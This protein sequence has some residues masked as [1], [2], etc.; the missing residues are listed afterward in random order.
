MQSDAET[1]PTDVAE[2]GTNKVH[3]LPDLPTK[4][5]AFG[6]HRDL[7]KAIA[8]LV[9]SED[10]GKAIALEGGW[11]SGKSSVVLMLKTQLEGDHPES[12]STRVHVFD[13]WSHEGDPLRRVF[14]E[15]LTR[16]CTSDLDTKAKK[17]WE[18]RQKKEITGRKRET[19]QTTTPILK[20]RWPILF[21]A[22]L[23][24]YPVAIVALS[25]LFREDMNSWFFLL[26][27]VAAVIA[28]LPM[29]LLVGLFF[30]SRSETE[31]KLKKAGR[32]IALWSKKIDETTTTTAH[33]NFG[34]TSIEFQAYFSDLLSEY[35]ED[36]K[37][38]LILVLDN[39][40]RVPVSTARKLWVTL[41]VFADCCE[42]SNADWSKRVWFVVP[43]DPSAV[44]RIW[45]D[46][47]ELKNDPPDQRAGKRELIEQDAG[48]QKQVAQPV[49]PRL[50]AAFLDKTFQIRFDVPPLLLADWK[51]YLEALLV[52]AFGEGEV[53]S[54]EGHRVYWLS[55]TMTQEKKRP[56]TPR[57]LILYV[58]DIG[59]LKRRFGGI[60]PL[61]H[62]ALYAI[63]RRNGHDVRLWLLEE[64]EDR[65]RFA[66]LLGG[67]A[68]VDSLCAI[69][70][71]TTNVDAARS[72]LFREPILYYLANGESE[73][74]EKLVPVR[75]F[76][77]E[78]D[79]ICREG[80]ASFGSDEERVLNTLMVIELCKLIEAD[81]K[82][83]SSLKSFLA[84]LVTTVEWT[85]LNGDTGAGAATAIHFKL[86][87]RAS[88]SILR[89][90]ASAPTTEDVDKLTVADW[91]A[92]VQ[93]IATALARTK[94][95][96]RF[97]GVIQIA[98]TQKTI[99]ILAEIFQLEDKRR[100]EL[101]PLISLTEPIK[102]LVVSLAPTA[103]AEW[104]DNY[105]SATRALNLLENNTVPWSI[106]LDGIALRMRFDASLAPDE[107]TRLIDVLYELTETNEQA[108]LESVDALVKDG[109]L[110]RRIE[111]CKT[112]LNSTT[113]GILFQWA[114]EYWELG[115]VLPAITGAA[116]GLDVV[117]AIGQKPE[118]YPI[119]LDSIVTNCRPSDE[120][121]LL[122]CVLA[123]VEHIG[124]LAQIVLDRLRT[125]GQLGT[126]LDANVFV[127]RYVELTA[128]HAS[129]T[130]SHDSIDA[131]TTELLGDKSFVDSLASMQMS[132]NNLDGHICLVQ[133]GAM[134][135]SNK[136]KRTLESYLRSRTVEQWKAS[137]KDPDTSYQ[138][139]NAIREKDSAF[140]LTV[141]FADAFE[142]LLSAIL[143]G[144]DTIANVPDGWTH[145]CGAIQENQQST[146]ASK[147]IARA[148]R[149][150]QELAATIPLFA[151]Q[152][153]ASAV[154]YSNNSLVRNALNPLI[155]TRNSD[156][157][158]WLADVAEGKPAFWSKA[159]KD[160]RGTFGQILN[161][162]YYES[163]EQIQS[164]LKRIAS[165]FKIRIEEQRPAQESED[166]PQAIE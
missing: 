91:I 82:E 69:A 63:L 70:H 121:D 157:I 145:V 10:G 143:T 141:P 114:I 135:E 140:H 118:A 151:D 27:V 20:S 155:Q 162:T 50:S 127:N 62:L 96:K 101:A 8:E 59:A 32:L 85:E 113:G 36:S 104:S 125:D 35:L 34:P 129:G 149:P 161:N 102:T 30:Y 132:E 51:A 122:N 64:P 160:D 131:L 55:R 95:T 146:I 29:F 111:N 139:L 148:D 99:D 150:D 116:E 60:F 130:D 3:L 79:G 165:A 128:L 94:E 47:E 117:K 49:P 97:A 136:Y 123:E 134:S 2:K 37:K 158:D 31:E 163:D 86:G 11:G 6:P 39:L 18:D 57:H 137:L 46:A 159:P 108:T 100:H 164:S 107:V 89:Q 138:L 65:K 61:D 43:Y 109:N 133:N 76:W 93:E 40:D 16:V 1:H 41:R 112:I 53:S 26:F 13:A 5:D 48:A 84:A 12:A 75:G 72:L 9:E 54:D 58:N 156:A 147:L 152:L 103:D 66:S 42:N 153:R 142:Q 77:Q 92:G 110:F 88:K 71:G 73:N 124:P 45:D 67:E 106:I 90:L 81:V 119:V 19:D 22:I 68:Y 98:A 23:A 126:V 56:P 83:L 166:E 14:L 74:F 52:Q 105:A 38:R 33:E 120:N 144:D 7:A 78:L 15:H 17:R 115:E 28:L 44:R 154:Q 80:A 87:Q 21:L 24:A 4:D 25:R